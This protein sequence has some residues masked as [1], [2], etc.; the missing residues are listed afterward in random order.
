[1][2]YHLYRVHW[3]VTYGDGP[4]Q[5][6]YSFHRTGDDVAEFIREVYA[7]QKDQPGVR[8]Q[9]VGPGAEHKVS[10]NLYGRVHSTAALGIWVTA[11]EIGLQ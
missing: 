11:D 3:H 9:T 2:S 6:H 8:Y 5:D 7:K 4:Q 10:G 1:M